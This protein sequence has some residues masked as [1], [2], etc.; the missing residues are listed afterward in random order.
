M[1]DWSGDSFIGTGTLDGDGGRNLG[2]FGFDCTQRKFWDSLVGSGEPSTIKTATI[3][4][5]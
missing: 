4:R 3:H 1:G 5:Y 2:D